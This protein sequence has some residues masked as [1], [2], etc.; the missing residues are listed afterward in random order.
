[1]ATKK[2]VESKLRGLIGRLGSAG[3]EAQG[4][5]AQALPEPRVIQMDLSD[6]DTSFWTELARGELGPL[7]S[8]PTEDPDIR[9][10][11]KSDDL[12]AMIDGK[13][14]LFTSYLAGH[15]RVQ[16]NVQDLMALR[17]LL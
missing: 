5:L 11:A 6:L 13:K 1:V 3:K 9:V 12:I 15:I 14:N 2:D 17:K 16:A 7:H 4:Q 8:G 10:T